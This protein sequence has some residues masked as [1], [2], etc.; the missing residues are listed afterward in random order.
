MLS[1]YPRNFTLV[2][3][4]LM[5]TLCCSCCNSLDAE[6]SVTQEKTGTSQSS[7]SNRSSNATAGSEKA[8]YRLQYQFRAGQFVYYN[9]SHRSKLVTKY[10]SQ[11]ETAHNTADTLKH[12]RVISVDE[13]G[14]AL[15]DLVLDRTRMTA[16]FD[17]FQP[18][19]YDS[20]SQSEPPA[21]FRKVHQSIGRPQ[22]RFRSAPSG[23]L[24]KIYPLSKIEITTD[25]SAT[26][27]S[28]SSEDQD[29]KTVQVRR[30]LPSSGN[31]SESPVQNKSKSKANLEQ[32]VHASFFVLFPEKPVQIGES[33][34]EIFTVD[35]QENKFLTRKVKLI[36]RFRLE[37][38]K[39]T[40]A[41][42]K[43]ST[44]V[45][46]PNLSPMTRSQL[47]QRTPSGEIEFDLKR[48]VMIR[49]EL[50]IDNA[51]FGSFGQKSFVSAESHRIEQ[52]VADPT[53]QQT[54]KNKGI[55]GN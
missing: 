17:D 53:T 51:V 44:A 7:S 35:V 48:G 50:K 27:T 14:N 10:Q 47:V 21:K 24:L 41:F 43:M 46:T 12:Y 28:N 26:S 22:A 31:L 55:L 33:W 32:N 34:E 40:R 19:V 29:K 45:L 52:L 37:K 25:A 38:V 42:I 16:H 39:G 8:S 5:L 20:Q 15:L 11:S 4:A 18:T 3:Q 49:R 13:E 23:K 30:S 6:D 1:R 2:S 9:V 54:P 36:R